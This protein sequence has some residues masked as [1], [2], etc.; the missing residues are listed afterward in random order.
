MRQDSAIVHFNMINPDGATEA[1]LASVA[2]NLLGAM[3]IDAPPSSKSSKLL[4]GA[5]FWR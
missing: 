5:F 3:D 2:A 1:I 4:K